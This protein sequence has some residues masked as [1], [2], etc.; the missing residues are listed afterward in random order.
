MH[1]HASEWSKVGGPGAEH[2]EYAA[3]WWV[4]DSHAA[5][6]ARCVGCCALGVGSMGGHIVATA[7]SGQT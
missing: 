4:V 1:S 5:L 3:T 7:P 6:H 2:V